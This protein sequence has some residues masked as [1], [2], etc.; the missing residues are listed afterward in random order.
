[1]YAKQR[2]KR[3]LAVITIFCAVFCGFS[4]GALADTEIKVYVNG[5]KL[6]FDAEPRIYGG[7]TLVP[8]R[9]VFS[10]L[11]AKVDW[12][13]Q[14][15]AVKAVRGSTEIEL[16]P[17]QSSISVNGANHLI[18]APAVIENGR[19]LVPLRAV[20]QAFGCSVIW[21][22]DSR[23]ASIGTG[24][25]IKV[26]FLYCGQA[27]C[28]FIELPN[29]ECMLVD[30]GEA[31]FGDKLVRYIKSLGYTKIDCIVAT[32]PH[33]DHIGGMAKVLG[34]FPVG[35]FYMPERSYTTKTFERMLDALE[36]NGCETDYIVAGTSFAYGGAEFSAAAPIRLDYNRMNNVSAVLKMKYG[37]VSVIFC[38]DA[39][40]DSESD[41]LL[42]GADI[43]A[44][45][46]KIG[47]HGSD[48]SSSEPFLRAVNPKTAVISDGIGNKY[49]FPSKLVTERLEKLGV[50][51][52][53]TDLN[54][55]ITFESDGY[56]YGIETER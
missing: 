39:E 18:D 53:R 8:L 10:A 32:H 28:E 27:D 49:G 14:I 6:S 3:F 21:N 37:S 50:Q 36:K 26:H 40:T 33:A 54:G 47:H 44:D 4:Y 29:G 13:E 42:S 20:A 9:G 23:T 1:M 35:K 15:K 38:G 22:G 17:G 12:D 7:R 46:I 55:D 48:T 45:V 5:E 30:S 41:I 19:T 2:L 52:F 51:I 34:A 24:E 25:K 43:S 16:I 11:G 56:F 31:A